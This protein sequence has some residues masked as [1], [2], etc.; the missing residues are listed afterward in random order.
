MLLVYEHPFEQ[1]VS[2]RSMLNMTQGKKKVE[3]IQEQWREWI[4][5]ITEN[6]TIK[7]N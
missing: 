5:S 7:Q 4:I 1:Q 6:M 3:N 2:G